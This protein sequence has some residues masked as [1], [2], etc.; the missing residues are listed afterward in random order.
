VDARFEKVKQPESTVS[1]I[2][3]NLNGEEFISA[4]LSAVIAEDALSEIIVVD[5][6]SSDSSV[7]MIRTSFPRAKIIQNDENRGFAAPANQ[8]AAL[9]SGEYLLFLNNDARLTP[10][11]LGHLVS[12]L[13]DEPDVAA[14]EPTM[15][16][17][18]G[19]LDSA[20]S[21]FTKTGFPYHV[22]EDEL[23]SARFGSY[24]FSLKG[25]CLLIRAEVFHRAGGFD[26]SYF[27][28]FEETD[29]C[30]RLLAMGYRLKHIDQALVIH[31]VGRT[32]TAVFSS[33]H[34]DFLSFRN[35]I[36][37]IRKDGSRLLKLRVLPV[38]IVCCIGF[39]A[40][41]ALTGKYKNAF[42]ITRALV[43]HLRS[44]SRRPP[45][46][47]RPQRPTSIGELSATT[48]TYNASAIVK[49]LKLYLVRW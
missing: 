33:A 36:T 38:H 32:T 24:R 45:L 46:I 23:S 26:G 19:T 21:M 42:A 5:N 39:A 35:R 9:A 47:N 16:R 31:D 25:A 28:Y 14:C 13:R 7:Q 6:G 34:I 43:W 4:C 29:L 27:A 37:T 18:D 12:G 30:W 1:I 8:G 17:N 11:S 49:M 20:G 48:V 3:V 41:F 40:V 2:I 15:R 44:S 10:G 22:S